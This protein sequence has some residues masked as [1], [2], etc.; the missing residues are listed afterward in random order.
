MHEPRA[1]QLFSMHDQ[2]AG[3]MV[4]LLQDGPL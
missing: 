3:G 4:L 2:Q 1:G